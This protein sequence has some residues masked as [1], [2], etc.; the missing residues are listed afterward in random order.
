[1]APNSFIISDVA[2]NII[3]LHALRHPSNISGVLLGTATQENCTFDKALPLIHSDL[4]MFTSP[5]HEMA[6]L[7]G[8]QKA[9]Q[10]NQQIIGV[11]F[12]NAISDDTSIAEVPTRLANAVQTRLGSACLLMI[13]ANKLTKDVRRKQ[14]AFRVYIREGEVSG[15]WGRS[16]VESDKLQVSERALKLADGLVDGSILKNEQFHFADFEDHCNDPCADWLNVDL[17]SRLNAAQL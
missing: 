6:L 2:Y 4:T 17:S 10:H 14:H 12:S 9:R 5:M 11:Y 1:M 13:D 8:E 16:E 3:I 7:L 15:T